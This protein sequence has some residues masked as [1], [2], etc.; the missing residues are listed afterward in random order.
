MYILFSFRLQGAFVNL[1]L[2]VQSLNMEKIRER[3]LG[4]SPNASYCL[5]ITVLHKKII[6]GEF[7]IEIA[8][9]GGLI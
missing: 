4:T 8:Y 7:I 9:S 3:P 6:T 1:D 2:S 5:L